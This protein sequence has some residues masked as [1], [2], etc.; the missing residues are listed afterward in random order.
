M[1]VDAHEAELSAILEQ[2]ARDWIADAG[3][4]FHVN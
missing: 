1:E 2:A 4:R 3:L